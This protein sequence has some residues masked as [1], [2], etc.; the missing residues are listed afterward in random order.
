MKIQKSL[1]SGSKMNV[2]SV[3]FNYLTVSIEEWEIWTSTSVCDV[4]P[5]VVFGSVVGFQSVRFQLDDVVF[6]GIYILI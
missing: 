5:I 6:P 1:L 4:F 2:P 3:G